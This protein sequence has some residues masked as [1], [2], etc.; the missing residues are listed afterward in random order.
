VIVRYGVGVDNVDL[1]AATEKG[2][3]VANV[4][5]D[6]T[7]VADHAVSLVL[8][9]IRKIPLANRNVRKGLWDWKTVQ[10]ISRLRGKTVGIIGFGRIGRKVAQRLKG[11]EVKLIAYDPYVPEN[12]FAEYNVERVNFETLIKEADIIMVHASLTSETRHLIGEDELK[13]MKRSAIL[14]N[15]SRGSIIDEKALYKALKEGWISG[16]GLDVL[17]KEPPERNNPLLKLNN[18]IITPHM[19]WYSIESL[20]EIRRIAAEEVVRALSGQI[21]TSLV[22]R[23]VLKKIKTTVLK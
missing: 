23:D 16:A 7:D 13:S 11:F 9:L 1:E 22:N 8:S 14:V 15:T 3:F 6:V 19:A 10:P 5:Y 21:P 12:V 17:E 18:V 2:I 20:D 4:M